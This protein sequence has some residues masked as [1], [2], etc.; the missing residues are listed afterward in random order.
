VNDLKL[1]LQAPNGNSITLWSRNCSSEDSLDLIF[2]DGGLSLQDE[3]SEC[4]NPVTGVYAPVDQNTNLATLFSSGTSGDWVLSCSDFYPENTGI[5]NRWSIEICSTNFSVETNVF[6]DFSIV[7]NPNNGVFTLNF[8]Q[9]LGN[10]ANISIYDLRGRLVEK[11]N[12]KQNTV[13][14]LIELQ[15]Q[16]QSG[17][18]LLEIANDQGKSI[19]KLVIN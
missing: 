5:L 8:N 19:K 1:E 10:N 18:Y 6:N 13:P 16:P 2:N 11:I 17:V 14:L 12:P 9:P 15:N 3:G 7:P 4:S